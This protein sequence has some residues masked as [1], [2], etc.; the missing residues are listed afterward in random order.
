MCVEHSPDQIKIIQDYVK[1]NNVTVDDMAL[2]IEKMFG[3]RWNIKDQTTYNYLDSLKCYD[4]PPP[5]KKRR[6]N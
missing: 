6:Y 5:H 3:V 2:F 4:E 1:Q